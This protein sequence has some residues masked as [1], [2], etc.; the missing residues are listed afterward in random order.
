MYVLFFERV[1]T[2]G[3]GN[4]SSFCSKGFLSDCPSLY[5]FALESGWPF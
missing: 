4:I 1:L 3:S 2:A 5:R